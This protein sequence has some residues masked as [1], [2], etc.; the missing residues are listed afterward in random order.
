MSMTRELWF[1][2]SKKFPSSNEDSWDCAICGKSCQ[3]SDLVCTKCDERL[4]E[5]GIKVWAEG[6]REEETPVDPERVRF[7]YYRALLS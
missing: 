2:H 3:F 6:M 7:H 4:S 1:W 5:D